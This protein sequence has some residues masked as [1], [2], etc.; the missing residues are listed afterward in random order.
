MKEWSEAIRWWNN[1][2]VKLIDIRHNVLHSEQ[3]LS[4]TILPAP[5]FL[6]LSKGEA[7]IQFGINRFTSDQTLIL[8]GEKGTSLRI[9]CMK[10]P[11]DYY[12]LLYKPQSAPVPL[13]SSEDGSIRGVNAFQGGEPYFFAASYPLT[14]L[15]IVEKMAEFWMSSDELER[16]QVTGLF[17]QFVYEQFRQ[18][19]M[20]RQRQVE[21][22]ELAEQIEAYIQEHYAHSISM[23]NMAT[24]FHYSTHY[25]ARVFK[26][27]YGCSPM[28]YVIQT[29]IKRAKR[30]LTET[31]A[32]I[33]EVAE[34]VGYK[35]LYY[36]SRIF[37]RI[38]GETPAQYKMHSHRIK[39]SNRTNKKSESFIDD[40]VI[41]SYIGNNDNHYQYNTWS[42]D[43][44]N[45]RFKPTLAVSL[46]F[47]LSLLLAAC[48]AGTEQ[49]QPAT[50][51]E[52]VQESTRTYTDATG[53]KVEIP[54][55]PSKPVIITYGG[56]L[57]PLGMKPAGANTET[58]EQYPE[59][60]AGVPDIGSGNGNVEMISGLE[61]DVII[62]PDYTSKEIVDTY[63]KIA[64]TITVAWGGDPDVINTLRTMG[65][66][67]DR[68][69]EAEQWIAKFEAKLKS[70]RSE[71]NINIKPGT[72]AMSFVIYNKEVLLGGEGGTLG[73][74]I[75]EDFG[76]SMPEQY[77]IYSDGG[78]VLSLEKLA[79]KPA[80][81]F[82]TQMEDE[83]MDQMME[84]FEEPVYQSIPAI[85]HN[86]IINVSRNYWNYGPY[87]A[88]KGLDSLIEQVKKLQ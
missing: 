63:A 4:T 1:N 34:S 11:L 68:K 82:F 9:R 58:L 22:L 64:P 42:V 55:Q 76:F 29:R 40:R 61:P 33:R 62:V 37:K 20:A 54:A 39:G 72:T 85:K 79:D 80:D 52:P 47:S 60:L 44:L 15:T 81:Y 3:E 21:S 73:K 49:S 17:Y 65:D 10:E 87:L 43:E 66:I 67:M 78:T 30:L 69:D 51:A 75:Y 35:D 77:K 88:D 38:T 74:L 59:E 26:R 28:D 13:E 25:L 5:A 36:F 6:I 41:D 7:D 14:L 8:H 50:S 70:I 27:K 24:H 56:Y 32:Q 57:L 31:E 46:L 23:E 18:W 16:L 48:G 84:L 19:K 53:R 12:L 71:L 2:Q 86:R 45:L 83:E